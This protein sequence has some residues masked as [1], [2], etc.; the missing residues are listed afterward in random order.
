MRHL[1]RCSENVKR[2][3]MWTKSQRGYH[4]V[5]GLERSKLIGAYDT[6]GTRAYEHETD[7]VLN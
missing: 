5:G 7:L 4:I 6:M 2:N 3:K 1:A